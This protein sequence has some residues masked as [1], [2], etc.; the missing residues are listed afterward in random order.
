L[1]V[2]VLWIATVLALV[3]WL[4]GRQEHHISIGAGPAESET[5]GL[6]TAI[7]DVLNEMDNG[8]EISVFETG[9]TTENMELLETGQIDV[10]RKLEARRR[11]GAA[12]QRG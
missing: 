6:L 11:M 7:A 3:L 12:K 4:G 1:L 5:F 9:G 10:A 2:L 8:L